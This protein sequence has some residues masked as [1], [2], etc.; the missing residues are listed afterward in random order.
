[1]ETLFLPQLV[2]NSPNF[3]GYIVHKRQLPLKRVW[4]VVTQP[5]EVN[6][7]RIPMC[8]LICAWNIS[9]ILTLISIH[10]Q[11]IWCTM[12]KLSKWMSSCYGN[13]SSTFYRVSVAFVNNLCSPWVKNSMCWQMDVLCSWYIRAFCKHVLFWQNWEWQATI[14]ISSPSSFQS[15]NSMY[16]W[17]LIQ[18]QI[19]FGHMFCSY[20]WHEC[21]HL[22]W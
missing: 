2:L 13:S 15:K 1:M 21:N 12:Y 11:T 19:Q 9:S 7:L 18:T 5:S 14:T 4:Q 3:V 6:F 8:F 22:W 17:C 20:E 10:E 16:T